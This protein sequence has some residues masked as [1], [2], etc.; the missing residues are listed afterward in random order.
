MVM[1]KCEVCQLEVEEPA[2]CKRCGIKFCYHCGDVGSRVCEYCAEE[3][4]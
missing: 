4:L 3:L 2:K 1:P